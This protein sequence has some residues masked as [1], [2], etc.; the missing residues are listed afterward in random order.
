MDTSKI[1]PQERK[2]VIMLNLSYMLADVANSFCMDAND[3]MAGM[4]KE[5]RQSERMK[6][7]NM[8]STAKRLQMQTKIVTE[9]F[10]KVP[11]VNLACEESDYMYDLIMLIVDR[12]GDDSN[13]MQKL[14]ATIFN[15][16]KSTL[17]I[18]DTSE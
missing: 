1:D 4:G 10:Y 11:A 16:F 15:Q 18:Y 6:F 5:L 8:A 12:I 13:T 7:N 17:G 9:E 3:L 14:R 2:A